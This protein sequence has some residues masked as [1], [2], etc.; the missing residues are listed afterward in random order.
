MSEPNSTAQDGGELFRAAI[1]HSPGNPFHDAQAFEALPDGGLLVQLGRIQ[2]IGNYANVRAAYPQAATRD[3]RGGFILPGLIDL[4]VHFPQV[5]VL[6]SLGCTLLDWLERHALPEESRMSDERYA[7]QVATEFVR[8]LASHGTTAAL[9][10][11]AHFPQATSIF[12]DTAEAAGLRVSSGMVLSDR[13]LRP[14]LHQTPDAAYRDSK[15]LIAK[16]HGRKRLAYAITPRFAVSASEAMLDVCRALLKEHPD[17][18][19]QT[20]LNENGREISEVARLFPW[21]EDYLAVYERF[22]LVHARS[23]FAHNVHPTARELHSLATLRATIAHCPSSNAALGSGIFPLRRHLEAGVRF[24]LGTDVGAGTGFGML[25][26][27]L[28]AYLL[29]RLAPDG[30]SLTPAQLL[31]LMTRAG[32]EALGVEGEIGDLST[33]KAADFV[34]LRPPAGGP[35]ASIVAHSEAPERALAALFTLASTDCIREVRVEGR[36]VYAGETGAGCDEARN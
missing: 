29:Q 28:Q 21:A 23:V 25:K 2:A 26:E 3:L 10:F 32:A 17:L 19:L 11:G 12:F 33:G 4:H 24:A 8:A 14:E 15:E 35:L 6:G 31:Y 13:L 18:L 22:G 9:V 36:V 34:Y 20:H 1:F 30:V 16:Y 5:R 27:G 7:R